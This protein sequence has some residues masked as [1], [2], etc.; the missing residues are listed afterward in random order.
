MKSSYEVRA[1]LFIKKVFPF[2]KDCEEPEDY[3]IAINSYNKLHHRKVIVDYGMTRVV[4]ITSDYVVKIDYGTK[5][6]IWGSC[7]DEYQMYKQAVQDG[8]DYLFAK[9]TPIVFEDRAFYIMPR[10]HGIGSLHSGGYDVDE[11]LTEEENDWVNE[12][13]WDIH[14]ENYGWHNNRPVIIDYASRV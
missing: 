7:E 3:M 6:R 1:Q 9:V 11:W 8:F 2:I 13:C 12:H 10:I 5:S 14:E 4:L